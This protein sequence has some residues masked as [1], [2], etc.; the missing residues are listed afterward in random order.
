MGDTM[1]CQEADL[2]SQII[3]SLK[4]TNPSSDDDMAIPAMFISETTLSVSVPTGATDVCSSAASY[5]LMTESAFTRDSSLLVA[6]RS[7]SQSVSQSASQ[8]ASQ[9]A[10]QSASQSVSQPQSASQS[11]NQS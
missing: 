9:L 3:A 5:I 2:S 11:V 7:V 4:A 10:S 1:Q 8:S 6:L